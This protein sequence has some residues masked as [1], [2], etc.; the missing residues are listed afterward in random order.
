MPSLHV[1]LAEAIKDT[2]AAATLP[3]SVRVERAYPAV[4]TSL[5]H[6]ASVAGEMFV[7]PISHEFT[8]TSRVPVLN[9]LLGVQVVLRAK[10]DVSEGRFDQKQIDNLLD[11][12][13]EMI[14]AIQR[15][16]PLADCTFVSGTKDVLFDPEKIDDHIFASATTFNYRVG[17]N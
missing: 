1:Q 8:V 4:E 12:D 5:E 13:E 16:G 15:A 11:C 9:H 6:L 17:V 14:L 7:Y 2:I 3:L 10:I